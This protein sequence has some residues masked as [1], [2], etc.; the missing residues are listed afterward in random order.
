VLENQA[1][2]IIVRRHGHVLEMRLNRPDKRNAAT[3]DLLQR[4][5]SA[6]GELDRDPELRVGL[7]T[8]EGDHFTGGLDLADVG[9]HMGAD[10]LS[11]VPEGGLDPWGIHTAQV[12]KP[13][14]VAAKGTCYTLGIELILAADVSVAAHGTRF[15]QLEVQRGILPFGGATLRFAERC[16]WGNA[17]R[18]ML[19]G[20]TF[21]DAEAL[22]IGLVQETCAPDDVDARALALAQSIAQAA[23]LAVAATLA[24]AR[25]ARAAG[26][27]EAGARLQPELMRLMASND[28]KKGFVAFATRQQAIFSG[29]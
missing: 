14:V 18:W 15:A 12:T 13:V 25:L 2:S 20:E 11:Y 17:M 3:L 10:G 6:Y 4:L 21:D 22:R 27:A 8:A 26:H 23:P 5:A 9:K 24:N 7:V 19:T 28:A 16:G 29:D 1:E